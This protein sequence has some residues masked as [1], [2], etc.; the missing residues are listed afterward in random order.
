MGRHLIDKNLCVS[1]RKS[2]LRRRLRRQQKL[3][4]L[5]NENLQPASLSDQI[6]MCS[7]LSGIF[8]SNFASSLP[9]V[10]D[11]LDWFSSGTLMQSS[12]EQ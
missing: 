10:N 3:R 2:S 6:Y 7:Y 4:R 11:C 1:P 8:I 5:E 12:T 9:I